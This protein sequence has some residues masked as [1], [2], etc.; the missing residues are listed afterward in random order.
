MCI[1][2]KSYFT[3]NV[4]AL[5]AYHPLLLTGSVELVAGGVQSVELQY[6]FIPLFPCLSN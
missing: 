2:L 4:D 6:P 5:L 1:R 3:E